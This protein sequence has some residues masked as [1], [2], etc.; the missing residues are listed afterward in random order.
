[1]AKT[2]FIPYPIHEINFLQFQEVFALNT[3]KRVH[4]SQIPL[5]LPKALCDKS[6]QAVAEDSANAVYMINFSRIDG[7]AIDQQP[8]MIAY[9]SG[10]GESYLRAGFYTMV[11]GMEGQ[12]IRKR[13]FLQQ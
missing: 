7:T 5:P 11:A 9:H 3:Y 1:M 10:D 8:L 13:H 2:V 12:S 6:F 4:P